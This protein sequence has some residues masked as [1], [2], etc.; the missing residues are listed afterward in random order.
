MPDSSGATHKFYLRKGKEGVKSMS[1]VPGGVYTLSLSPNGMKVN[2][3]SA[4]ET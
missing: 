4:D 3:P 2:G 1:D